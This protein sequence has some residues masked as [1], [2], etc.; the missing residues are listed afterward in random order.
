MGHIRLKQLPATLKWHQ[1][2]SLIATG[3]PVADVAKASAEA[4]EDALQ[5]VRRD[6]SL[7]HS[8]WLLTQIP[9]A[10]RAPDFAAAAAAVGVKIGAD[11]SLMELVGAFSGALDDVKARGP[12]LLI[13]GKWRSVQLLRASQHPSAPIC[14]NYSVRSPAMFA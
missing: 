14:P 6:P 8:F 12:G 2:V 11:P 10:A 13:S 4:A 1:V 5:H 9:L 3:A 7:A